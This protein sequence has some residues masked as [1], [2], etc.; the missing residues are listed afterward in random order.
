MI[1]SFFDCP[2]TSKNK[3]RQ[4]WSNLKL[5]L[6]HPEQVH[7]QSALVLNDYRYIVDSQRSMFSNAFAAPPLYPSNGTIFGAELYVAD[8]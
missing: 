5:F 6:G 4:S 7:I 3:K 8:P 2:R 1:F